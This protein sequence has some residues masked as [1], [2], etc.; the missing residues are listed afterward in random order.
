MSL[1]F[2]LGL[3]VAAVILGSV[4]AMGGWFATLAHR[5]ALE[6]LREKAQV[7]VLN[8]ASSSREGVYNQNLFH[9]LDPLIESL[10]RDPDVLRAAVLD[11]EGRILADTEASRVG[12]AAPTSLHGG[13]W[14]RTDTF[15][16]VQREGGATF[17][18]VAPVTAPT[19]ALEG[20]EVIGAVWLRLSFARLAGELRGTL[21][22]SGAM[23]LA[24]ALAGIVVGGFFSYRLTRP[25]RRIVEADE[26]EVRG[27]RARADIP[28]A[29]IPPDEVG[30]IM[31]SRSR[32]REA[33]RES[34][35]RYRR[36]AEEEHLRAAQLE[37]AYGEL[38][39][40][41][42]RFT[43][44]EKLSLMGQ[45]LAGVGHEINNPLTAV[46]GYSQLLLR[47]GRVR[48]D[49]PLRASLEK[50]EQQAVRCQKIVKNLLAFGRQHEAERRPVGLNALIADCL[51]LEAT[52][53]TAHNIHVVRHLDPELP[54]TQADYFR[55]QQVF[56][57]VLLNAQQAMNEHRG[58]G[59]LTVRTR[60][61]GGHLRVEVEDDGPGIPPE[62][63]P[64]IFEPFFT[65][66]EVG[67]GTGLGL[68]LSYGI[69]KEHGGELWAENRPEGGARFVVEL[70]LVAVAAA[71]EPLVL[72][73]AA[74]PGGRVLLIEDEPVIRELLA[75]LMRRMGQEVE[76]ACDGPAA[77][78]RLIA[79]DYDAVFCDLHLPG[80]DGAALYRWTL[81]QRPELAGC[82]VFMTGSVGAETLASLR[83]TG[84]PILS[85]PFDLADV[86]A[87]LGGVL[88]E[89]A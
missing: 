15:L 40:L 25:L 14:P 16:W 5:L 64:R 42:E 50:V 44:A 30:L 60:R 22:R 83:D 71:P 75:E 2:R 67:K 28:E 41:R 17:E 77:F 87:I 32:M 72:P 8:L 26:A 21:V 65:T 58:S 10:H 45:L 39:D 57:N 84:R 68:S 86:G 61:R 53:I 4:I 47:E 59:T 74:P 63:M 34:G 7:L 33:L 20:G 35:E 66:K 29:E 76:V 3:L 85:K 46:I 38:K 24:L 48:A 55:L 69:V 51:E 13:R 43:Q 70:P 37:Q 23:V 36:L 6:R 88:S 11:Q 89:A 18:I 27:D 62:V 79:G 82:W 19:G 78:E 49:A 56:L 9:Q 80:A 31:R 52:Q 54:T 12:H 81:E 1:R 73:G